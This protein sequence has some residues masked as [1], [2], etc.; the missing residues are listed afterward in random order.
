MLHATSKP[1]PTTAGI[2]EGRGAERGP[3]R[4]SPP[5]P[6]FPALAP[7][8]P[9]A[10]G[11]CSLHCLPRPRH[12]LLG[13]GVREALLPRACFLSPGLEGLAAATFTLWHLLSGKAWAEGGS[14]CQGGGGERPSLGRPRPTHLRAHWS[15][16][17]SRA[18]RTRDE[19]SWRGR[20]AGAQARTGRF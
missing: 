17:G 18:R 3:P 14:R 5:S 15:S 13:Q 12:P 11:R 19:G 6:D 10:Q 16:T 1:F 9:R 2:G 8:W 4:N 7:E 20:V